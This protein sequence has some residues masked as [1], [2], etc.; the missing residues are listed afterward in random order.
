M[1]R[2]SEKRQIN[3]IAAASQDA[4]P[5]GLSIH[6]I[7]GEYPASWPQ[8]VA[9]SNGQ[10]EIYA[11]G[12][13]IYDDSASADDQIY[14]GR[15]LAGRFSYTIWDGIR[16]S[17]AFSALVEVNATAPAGFVAVRDQKEL[18]RAIKSGAPQIFL[19]APGAYKLKRDVRKLPNPFTLAG[20]AS[21]VVDIDLAGS[22]PGQDIL[23]AGFKVTRQARFAANV[24]SITRDGVLFDG[25]SSG[26]RGSDGYDRM[27]RATV[28]LAGLARAPGVGQSIANI[29]GSAASTIT[30]VYDW[31]V[32]TGRA[33]VAIN[34]VPSK[35]KGGSK[36]DP[37]WGVGQGLVLDGRLAGQV[38]SGLLGGDPVLEN[39]IGR[40]QKAYPEYD[41]YKNCQFRGWAQQIGAFGAISTVIEN[42]SFDGFT[43]DAIKIF[44]RAERPE[45]TVTIRGNRI[46]GVLVNPEYF[47][48]PHMDAIQ[49]QPEPV[50]TPVVFTGQILIE[51][52][53]MTARGYN[54]VAD[55]QGII[56]H[57]HRN[58]DVVIRNNLIDTLRGPRGISAGES[59]VTCTNNTVISS[60][61]GKPYGGIRA[62][63]VDMTGDAGSTFTGCITEVFNGGRVQASIELGKFGGPNNGAYGLHLGGA[64]ISD[65]GNPIRDVLR[66]ATPGSAMASNIGAVGTDGRLRG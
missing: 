22:N 37:R 19:A 27:L 11:D 17:Q 61:P 2:Y 58:A 33:T 49:I 44:R 12:T 13:V 26:V 9:L 47:R 51:G 52:N 29:D 14:Q 50:K 36:K 20:T 18:E 34:D 1:A 28:D 24:R 57:Q 40:T 38:A 53:I 31:S 10:A 8:L 23:L 65:T 59:T 45:A 56:I 55:V 62:G 48:N 4:D 7:N 66:W 64:R 30:K 6:R 42:C 60:D 46:T 5:S 43:N 3:L 54:P 41:I 15:R 32:T 16:E 35:S 63:G 25:P 39:A 21:T